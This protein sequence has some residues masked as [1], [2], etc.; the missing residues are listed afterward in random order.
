MGVKGTFAC[1]EVE[2]DQYMREVY[3]QEMEESEKYVKTTRNRY[4]I[5]P[6]V[7]TSSLYNN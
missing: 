4:N 2:I 6:T 5:N 7:V 1:H 3:K